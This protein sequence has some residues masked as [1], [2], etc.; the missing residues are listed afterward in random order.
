M[1]YGNTGQSYIIQ[2][3]DG[4]L[5]RVPFSSAPGAGGVPP[6]HYYDAEVGGYVPNKQAQFADP[7]AQYG[8][9]Q[10]YAGQYPP[11]AAAAPPVGPAQN[12]NGMYQTMS[13]YQKTEASGDPLTENL[14]AEVR[15][16]FI[17]KVY[18]ILA[19]QLVLTFG[20]VVS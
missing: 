1:T 8:G 12:G 20:I 16:G 18:S 9:N 17:R 3:A 10:P 13:S 5:E 19:A 7:Y 4:T 15:I 6:N 11:Y 2:R 14:P